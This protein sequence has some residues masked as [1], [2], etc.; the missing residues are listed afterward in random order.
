MRARVSRGNVAQRSPQSPRRTL[1]SPVLPVHRAGPSI[2]DAELA[3]KVIEHDGAIV[4][5]G[6]FAVETAIEHRLEKGSPLPRICLLLIPSL[7]VN[8][9]D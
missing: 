4:L 8:F 7:T 6:K 9:K 2:R 3:G 1:D 5:A